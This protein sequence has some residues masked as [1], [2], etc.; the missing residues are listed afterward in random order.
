VTQIRSHSLQQTHK[1]IFMRCRILARQT[2]QLS[3]FS[4]HAIH[5]DMCPQLTLQDTAVVS[6][7]KNHS[8]NTHAQSGCVS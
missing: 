1:N 7:R 3:T 2:G 4:A 5:I 8:S 6:N